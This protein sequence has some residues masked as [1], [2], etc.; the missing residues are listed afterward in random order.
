MN[1]SLTT[2]D[3]FPRDDIDVAQSMKKAFQGQQHQKLTSRQSEQP[4]P[5]SY[6]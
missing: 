3:G 1:T 5:E 4:E 2:F 6:I